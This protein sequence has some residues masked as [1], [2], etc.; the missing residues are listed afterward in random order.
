M[1]MK[2]GKK[3]P[4]KRI[5]G[6]VIGIIILG[7]GISL[8]KLSVLGNDPSSA[9][10]MAIGDRIG[11][12]FAVTLLAANCLWF[13]AEWKWGRH[14]IGLGTFVNWF[15]V[16][17]ISMFFT[18]LLAPFLPETLEMY[19]KLIIMAV[20]VLVLSFAS[21]L[22]QTA[23]L[24]IAPYDSLALMLDERT[25]VP[26]FWCRI[27]T[28]VLCVIICLIFGGLVGIGTVVCSL[29]LGP[30]IHFFNRNVSEKLLKDKK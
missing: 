11:V 26:Y 23:D 1:Q 5:I 25:P 4:W 16:G 24:G 28:D 9:M 18:N 12:N 19:Q 15:G 20:G 10:V 21:S 13:L 3:A 30:F 17:T 14:Y 27:A 29:G 6:M 22:Y 7:L 8:F 2:V